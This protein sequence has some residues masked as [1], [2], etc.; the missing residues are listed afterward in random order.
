FIKVQHSIELICQ[1]SHE[2]MADSLCL[3]PV[4]YT[5]SS[6]QPFCAKFLVQAIIPCKSSQEARNAGVMKQA[7]IAFRQCWTHS[8]SF[9]GTAPIRS[10]RYCAA[11]SRKSDENRL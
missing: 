7:F 10:S 2:V 6:L 11:I 4:D 5:D 3:G 1:P 8:L 9:V